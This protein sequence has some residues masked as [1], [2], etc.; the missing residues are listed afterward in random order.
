MGPSHQVI[1]A[2][3]APSQVQQG[4]YSQQ[5]MSRQQQ[6]PCLREMN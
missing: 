2:Q 3:Q 1:Y 6:Q 5:D 4:Q